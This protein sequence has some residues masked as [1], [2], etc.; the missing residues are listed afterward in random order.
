MFTCSSL[1]SCQSKILLLIALVKGRC[2][3]RWSGLN[4]RS[5]VSSRVEAVCSDMVEQTSQ[6]QV[7]T[8]E[9]T[10]GDQYF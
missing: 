10:A 2:V 6:L 9:I 8:G 5:K 3:L 7:T 4:D 1:P